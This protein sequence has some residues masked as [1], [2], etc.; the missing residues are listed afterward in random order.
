MRF[1][2]HLQSNLRLPV[3]QYFRWPVEVTV[4]QH[5]EKNILQ[6]M[7]TRVRL[8]LEMSFYFS[9]TDLKTKEKGGDEEEKDEEG[10]INRKEKG[11]GE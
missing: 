10:R 2:A 8:S 7:I 5:K 9:F 11:E 3:V 4:D 1:K 6:D